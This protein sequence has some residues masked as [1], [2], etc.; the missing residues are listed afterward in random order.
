MRNKI[1]KVLELSPGSSFEDAKKS[2]RRLSLKYHPDKNKEPDAKKYLSIKD[3]FA[4]IKK[5]KSILQ[6]D[7]LKSG[8]KGKD[9][10][11]GFK[12]KTFNIFFNQ[13][14]PMSYKAERFCS[15]CSGTGSKSKNCE[16]CDSCSGTGYLKGGVFKET[17]QEGVCLSCSGTGSKVKEEDC[18]SE[19]GGTSLVSSKCVVMIRLQNNMRDG[20]VF[21]LKEKG[22]QGKF[23]GSKGRL[24]V[25]LLVEDSERASISPDG[26]ILTIKIDLSPA[27]YLLGKEVIVD[28]GPEGEFVGLIKSG[29]SQDTF[30]Y[31]KGKAIRLIP[32]IVWPSLDKK[33]EA[34]YKRI[35]KQE[36]LLA[37]NALN[38]IDNKKK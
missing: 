10:S 26:K 37:E 23:L 1:L 30:P 11:Y 2:Y 27:E 8:I 25:K 38:K 4:Q 36:S 32:N 33:T 3:A 35:L 29:D 17:G 9:L 31:R 18:C 6:G 12:V 16:I 24:F 13:S 34:L 28:F 20:Q 5:D 15:S 7:A 19:C 21:T 14:L 22:H